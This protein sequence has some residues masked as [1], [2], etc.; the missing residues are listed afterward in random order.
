MCSGTS[1]MSAFVMAVGLSQKMSYVLPNS[2]CPRLLTFA[3]KFLILLRR[4]ERVW[5]QPGPDTIN[6]L[7]RIYSYLFQMLS[8]CSNLCMG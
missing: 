8:I 1:S 3:M 5:E 4:K 6:L 7:C 2:Q